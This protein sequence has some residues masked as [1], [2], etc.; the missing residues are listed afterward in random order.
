MRTM[1][2]AIIC[3]VCAMGL[4][5]CAQPRWAQHPP[6]AHGANG[7]RAP[8][9]SRPE[10]AVQEIHAPYEAVT[11]VPYVSA[12][13]AVTLRSYGAPVGRLLA[14]IMAPRHWTLAFATGAS[15]KTRVNVALD[16]VGW[17]TAVRKVAFDAGYV[18]VFD[19]ATRTVTI[20]TKATYLFQLPTGL[21]SGTQANYFVGGSTGG[22]SVSGS[23]T[24]G[25]GG[26]MSGGMPSAPSVGGA[27]TTG[28]SSSVPR[29]SFLVNGKLKGETPSGLV[30]TVQS[31]AG[32]GAKVDLDPVTGLL[33]V[34]ADAPGLE[35]VSGFIRHYI[36][37]ANTRV[38]IHA[39]ILR[40]QLS[41]QLQWGINWNKVI[42]DANHTIKIGVVGSAAQLAAGAA[43]GS[44]TS[45]F[46]LTYTTS[47]VNSV[48]TALRNLTG[49][50][51]LSQPA[52]L[53]QNGAPE[54]LY[55]G[56]SLPFVGSIQSTVTGLSG[57]SSTSAGVSYATSGLSL[58]LVPNVLPGGL[59]SVRLVPSI[60]RV[61]SFQ[62][63][64][65]GTGTITGPVQNVQQAFMQ[66]LLRSGR[67]AII[68]ASRQ[69]QRSDG[70]SGVPL[71]SRLPLLGLA[72]KGVNLG[73]NQTQL[74][75]L[76]RAKVLSPPQYD[77]LVGSYL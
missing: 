46:T 59:V 54:T 49:V 74:V 41:G 2:R 68:G 43:P 58:S 40:V 38:M 56:K 7:L 55:S 30:Q 51:I 5:A 69:T 71:L 11:P 42:Q 50:R 4:G 3:A 66:V 72:F 8:K 24:S 36:Q 15:P 13:D 35:R 67:T 57:S 33:S 60:T 31:M 75:I 47:S 63:F 21:F 9:P 52:L 16:R 32:S 70:Q 64:N 39:A 29:A 44:A 27:G 20:A 18:A 28:S 73:G 25:V 14:G 53:A 19:E 62:S 17:K 48:I 26:G 37:V 10:A 1:C 76:L 77:P 22:A 65:V 45:P 61:D 12:A 23:G 34:T 6:W